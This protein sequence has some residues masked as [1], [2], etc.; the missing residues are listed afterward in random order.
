[1]LNKNL[2][3][4]IGAFVIVLLISSCSVS[5]SGSGLYANRSA[6]QI[7][8]FS[9]SGAEGVITGTNITVTV[10]YG[11]LLTA[12]TPTITCTGAS[13]SPET[14]VIQDFTHPVF[15]TVT[16]LD[17]SQQIYTVTVDV[18]EPSG[19]MIVTFNIPGQ[20]GATVIDRVNKTI[21]VVM[22]SGTLLSPL[23][24]IVTVPAEA[25]VNPVSEAP[26][27]FTSPVEYT[28]TASDGVTRQTYTVTV[29]DIPS[30]IATVTSTAYLVSTGGTAHET[31]TGV[32]KGTSKATFRAALAMGEPNQTWS[33]DAIDSTVVSGNSLA[34]TAH[35][36]TTIVTYTIAVNLYGLR[37][38]GPGGGLIFYVDPINAKLLTTGTYME[39]SL[40]SFDNDYWSNITTDSINSILGTSSRSVGKGM[41]NTNLIVGQSGHT[42]SAAQHC[43]DLADGDF[44]DWFLPSRDELGYMFTELKGHAVGDFGIYLYWSSSQG[45]ATTAYCQSF[46]D[47]N[48]FTV[49]KW[50]PYKGRC[51][52]VF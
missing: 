49:E 40:S 33:D 5:I 46:N 12:L 43:K 48:K 19:A 38:L 6:K 35:D 15:Y 45:T 52:R 28:V 17:K 2:S 42:N 8:A 50:Y 7:T 29:S 32:P 44:H 27:D 16:A 22:P 21:S 14:G 36:G 18:A 10:P 39:A 13:L 24:P 23:S 41:D 4:L 26:Q 25:T 34:V 9:I 20:E 51:A 47:G 30:N 37:E 11:S 31:I 3:G 1:M